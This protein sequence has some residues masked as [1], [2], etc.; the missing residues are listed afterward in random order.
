MIVSGE[1][2]PSCGQGCSGGDQIAGERGWQKQTAR[3]RGKTSREETSEEG[4]V[5][6]AQRRVGECEAGERSFWETTEQDVH[7]RSV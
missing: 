5:G 2:D 4:G 6:E 7:V 3:R 1:G